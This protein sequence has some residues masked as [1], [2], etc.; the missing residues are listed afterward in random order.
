MG[1]K[2]EADRLRSCRSGA[3]F[4]A[5]GAIFICVWRVVWELASSGGLEK[6]QARNC[7]VLHVVLTLLYLPQATVAGCCY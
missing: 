1:L 5:V 3:D 6:S 2:D 4:D 7:T